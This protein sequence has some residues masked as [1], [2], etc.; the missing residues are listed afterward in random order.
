MNAGHTFSLQHPGKLKDRQQPGHWQ[1]LPDPRFARHYEVSSAGTVRN[2][3]TGRLLKPGRTQSGHEKVTPCVNGVSDNV[4]VA[5]AVYEAFVGTIPD[6]F[7]LRHRDRDRSNCS[8]ENLWVQE[9]P[10]QRI[11]PEGWLWQPDRNGQPPHWLFTG[12]NSNDR[13][14]VSAYCTAGHP[15]SMTGKPNQNTEIHGF[16]NRI[17]VTCRDAIKPYP[18]EPGKY[19]RHYGVARTPS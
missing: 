19:S 1:P 3:R 17:C 6:G 15:L 11:S 14:K 7:V 16:G 13:S 9:A 18:H 2:S 10:V 5:P 12:K 8:L 4:Y